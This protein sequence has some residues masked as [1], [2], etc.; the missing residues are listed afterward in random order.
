[1]EFIIYQKNSYN[2]LKLTQNLKETILN[3]WKGTSKK[4][5]KLK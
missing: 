4:N 3:K 5:A 1:M 2:I